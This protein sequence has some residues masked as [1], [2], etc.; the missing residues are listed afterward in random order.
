MKWQDRNSS[1]AATAEMHCKHKSVI[2]NNID[3]TELFHDHWDNIILVHEC[4]TI[5]AV[6]VDYGEKTSIFS[7]I[8]Q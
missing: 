1:T 6:L 8:H 3:I 2:K 7:K 4:M 5:K